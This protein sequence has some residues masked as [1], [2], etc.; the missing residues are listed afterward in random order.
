[1]IEMKQ[2]DEGE[3][4]IRGLSEIKKNDLLIKRV[5]TDTTDVDRLD[6]IQQ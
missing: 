5:N 3:T 4:K 1:M 6:R 2:K